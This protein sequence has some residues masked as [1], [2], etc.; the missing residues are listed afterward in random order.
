MK[1][2]L[3]SKLAAA[4]IELSKANEEKLGEAL[5]VLLEEFQAEAQ[6]SIAPQIRGV[7]R[8]TSEAV[9]RLTNAESSF[10]ES[11]ENAHK[12]YESM[13]EAYELRAKQRDN[14]TEFKFNG[15]RAKIGHLFET[16][17]Q[18][19]AERFEERAIEQRTSRRLMGRL[20]GWSILIGMAA[21]AALTLLIAS[22]LDFRAQERAM[23]AQAVMGEHLTPI[24][25]SQSLYEATLGQ[26]ERGKLIFTLSEGREMPITFER[27]AALNRVNG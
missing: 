4:G 18:L 25:A 2:D 16:V 21:G 6:A 24:T 20:I 12:N 5:D 19:E 7:H 23:E 3:T 10:S 9:Q 1:P 22:W 26:T 8:K 17:D 14:L 11:Y 13:I 15:L 27:R